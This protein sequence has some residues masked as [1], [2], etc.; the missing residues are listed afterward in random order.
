[1]IKKLCSKLLMLVV[2]GS[3]FSATGAFASNA[4]LLAQGKGVFDQWCAM[5]HAAADR[6]PGTASLQAK[7]NG[8][9]PAALEERKDM[10]P[11]FVRHVVRNGVMIMPAF[12]TTEINDAELEALSSYLTHKI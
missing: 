3:G 2:C 6:M 10:T 11:E 4:A 8:S 5:C 12:R 7:Y 1:M 9:L